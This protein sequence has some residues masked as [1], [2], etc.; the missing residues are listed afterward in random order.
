MNNVCTCH[1]QVSPSPT[2]SS[3]DSVAGD[4]DTFHEGPTASEQQADQK[5]E[6]D[7]S[8]VTQEADHVPSPEGHFDGFSEQTKAQVK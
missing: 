1:L 2:I 6:D 3:G 4:E 5:V 8:R 7:M